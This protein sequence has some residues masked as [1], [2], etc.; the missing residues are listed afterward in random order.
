MANIIN[1][2]EFMEKVE[3]TK[4]VVMVDFFA[5]W[6]SPCKMLAPIFEEVSSEFNDKAKLFKLNVD[7]SGE[8][9]QKYGVF[10]IPTMIIFKDGKAVEN[11]AGFMPKE[12]ITNKLKAHL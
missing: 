2:Q 8:I 4:G 6:C 3:N 5:D 1:S 9:A 10:S 12:N 7:E 11:L